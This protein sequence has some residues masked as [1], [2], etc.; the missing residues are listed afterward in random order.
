LARGGDHA[1][2]VV[3][4]GSVHDVRCR[5]RCGCRPVAFGVAAVGVQRLIEL[6]HSKRNEAAA[7]ARGATEYGAR[8]Y[9]LMVGMHAAWLVSTLAEGRTCSA[10]RR[11]PLVVMIIAQVARLWVIRTLG[12]QWTTRIIVDPTA[13]PVTTGPYQFVNHPNYVVVAAEITAF[14]LVFGARRTALVFSVLNALVLR[15]RIRVE[16]TARRSVP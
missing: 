1:A 5:A 4:D 7:R 8:D 10:V 6:R 16:D 2:E 12:P 14:P 11:G 3:Y 9:P 13:A 15:Q